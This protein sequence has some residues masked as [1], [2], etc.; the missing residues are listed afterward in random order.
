MT[1]ALDARSTHA[2]TLYRV[3]R[4]SAKPQLAGRQPSNRGGVPWVR[5]WWSRTAIASAGA[6]CPV[7]SIS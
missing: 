2:K 1:P 5:T 7:V 4:A 3:K 6:V